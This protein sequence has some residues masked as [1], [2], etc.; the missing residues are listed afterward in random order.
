M[1]SEAHFLRD[2]NLR[3]GSAS[4]E[5]LEEVKG[6]MEE[7]K[8]RKDEI[9]SGYDRDERRRGSMFGV[10]VVKRVEEGKRRRQEWKRLKSVNE[11]GKMGVDD[12][13]TA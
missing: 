3:S 1:K 5:G 7:I 11:R 8:R 6:F 9:Q 10:G 12:R 13:P 4:K 2:P